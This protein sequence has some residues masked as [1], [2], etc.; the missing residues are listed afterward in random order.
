MLATV[1]GLRVKKCI[2]EVVF[3]LRR[4]L[5]AGQRGDR[6]SCTSATPATVVASYVATEGK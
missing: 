3:I 5:H 6:V 2:S 4:L 1:H